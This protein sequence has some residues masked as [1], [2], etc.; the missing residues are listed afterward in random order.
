MSRGCIEGP[1]E[2]SEHTWL[3]EMLQ[4]VSRSFEHVGAMW[5]SSTSMHWL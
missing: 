5:L 3:P 2:T 1:T 4:R